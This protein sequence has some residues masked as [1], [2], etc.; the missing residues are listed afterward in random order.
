[1]EWLEEE[2]NRNIIKWKI[3]LKTNKETDGT[4]TKDVQRRVIAEKGSFVFNEIGAFLLGDSALIVIQISE[5]NNS[6]FQSEPN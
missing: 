5:Q 2:A 4:I 3:D 1:M 6:K